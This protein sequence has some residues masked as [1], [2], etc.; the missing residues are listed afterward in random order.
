MARQQPATDGT[1]TVIPTAKV[2]NNAKR[3]LL[4][5]G[6]CPVHQNMPSRIFSGVVMGGWVFACGGAN[7]HYF[8]NRPPEEVS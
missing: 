3:G 7:G 1:Q 8:V 2:N 5:T 4:R 6:F